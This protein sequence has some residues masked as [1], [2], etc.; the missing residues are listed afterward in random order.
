MKK[1]IFALTFILVPCAANAGQLLP[2]LYAQK[3]CEYRA[4]GISDDDSR[5][6]AVY[7]AYVPTGT[8]IKVEYEGKMYSKDV[9]DSFLAA[10]DKCP[11][12]AK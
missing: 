1:F 10:V 7:H 4:L 12:F 5:R 8:P 6:A 3:F 9:L 11:Q 2:N